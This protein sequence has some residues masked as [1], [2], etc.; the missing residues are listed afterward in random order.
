[1]AI[2]ARRRASTAGSAA[3][4]AV[5]TTLLSPTIHRQRGSGGSGAR[6]GTSPARRRRTGYCG[7]ARCPIT[8]IDALVS[9][10]QQ[11]KVRR[12]RSSSP[13]ICTPSPS[14]P[15][16][17]GVRRS[18]TCAT[19][20]GGRGQRRMLIGGSNPHGRCCSWRAQSAGV[21]VDLSRD[22][23]VPRSSSLR[24]SASHSA[25]SACEPSGS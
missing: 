4:D 13:L 19:R 9:A 16:A 1:M 25:A 17:P 15:S 18:L 22:R 3:T 5:A 20:G 8:T 23:S 6:A 2:F 10:S 14:S 7:E 21:A 24:W 12:R 11:R